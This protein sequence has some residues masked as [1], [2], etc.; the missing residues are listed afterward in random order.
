MKKLNIAQYIKLF[1]LALTLLPAITNACDLRSLCNINCNYSDETVI[2]IDP[3]HAQKL[4]AARDAAAPAAQTMEQIVREEGLVEDEDR[5]ETK[6]LKRA[7]EEPSPLIN[8]IVAP[9]LVNQPSALSLSELSIIQQEHKKRAAVNLEDIKKHTP[10]WSTE[11]PLGK[12]SAPSAAL[13]KQLPGIPE[14]DLVDEYESDESINSTVATTFPGDVK[15]LTSIELL[16]PIID[17]KIYRLLDLLRYGN[18]DQANE[19]F[20][21]L[22]IE[23]DIGFDVLD[24]RNSKGLTPILAAIKYEFFDVVKLLLEHGAT[25]PTAETVKKI[26]GEANYATYEKIKLGSTVEQVLKQDFDPRNITASALLSER[27]PA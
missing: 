18:R 8:P 26:A 5:V 6:S 14:P 17:P 7:I 11:K 22:V 13:A 3:K 15:N 24:A 4:F 10:V 2:A 16:S 1:A 27:E 9:S 12:R 23:D 19:A 20:R 25:S 21:I